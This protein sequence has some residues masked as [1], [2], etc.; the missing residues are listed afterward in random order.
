MAELSLAS[1]RV[2]LKSPGPRATTLRPNFPLIDTQDISRLTAEIESCL[3]EGQPRVVVEL[4]ATRALNGE[5]IEALITQNNLL[6]PRGGWLQLA[7]LN[8]VSVEAL[9]LTGVADQ[10][11]ILDS[12]HLKENGGLVQKQRLGDMLVAQGVIS[13]EQVEEA[14]TQQKNSG[15]KLAG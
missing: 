6:R 4:T 1:D 10:I 13:E 8:S 3:E 15:R 12:D 2:V 11:A 14:L 5:L 7:K 9:H